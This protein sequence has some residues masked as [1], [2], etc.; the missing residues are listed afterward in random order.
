M[1]TVVAYTV[2]SS[3]NLI[4][5]DPSVPPYTGIARRGSGAASTAR[6]LSLTTR[7][8]SLAPQRTAPR[9]AFTWWI[10]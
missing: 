9:S 1:V 10:I 8:T 6:T 5:P 7:S 2:D 4:G 3:G